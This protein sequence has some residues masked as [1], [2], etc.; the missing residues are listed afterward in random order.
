M[1]IAPLLCR[2][3][4]HP[5]CHQMIMVHPGLDI[6]PPQEFK[7][8]FIPIGRVDYPVERRLYF[9][10]LEEYYKKH[11]QGKNISSS[12]SEVGTNMDQKNRALLQEVMLEKKM[13]LS[14]YLQDYILDSIIFLS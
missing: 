5:Q 10:L 8:N 2:Y 13:E 1:I 6:R 11:L 14:Q 3:L 12:H 4:G 7:R 9:A